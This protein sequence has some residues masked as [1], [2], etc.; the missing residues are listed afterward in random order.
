M[1]RRFGT[2]IGVDLTV[3]TPPTTRGNSSLGAHS[4][5]L[6]RR[7]NLA[8][9]EA[10]R[11]VHRY[12]IRSAFA[13]SALSGRA[14]LEP[15]FGLSAEQ[16]AWAVERASRMV[17]ELRTMDLRVAGD[18]TDLIPTPVPSAGGVDPGDTTEHELLQVALHGLAG[19][20]RHTA[21]NRLECNQLRAEI[22]RVTAERD[23][24]LKAIGPRSTS[25]APPPRVRKP[26]ETVRR[27]GG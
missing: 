18:L 27:T 11:V 17:A 2:A 5:E 1:A 16:H 21:R 10:A 7:V 8:I 23:A 19:M 15:E 26:R 4:A 3:L 20:A 13:D 14:N 24:L 25:V 9:P 12:G 22:E 6:I